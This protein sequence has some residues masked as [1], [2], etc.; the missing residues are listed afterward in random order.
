MGTELDHPVSQ[1]YRFKAPGNDEE[2]LKIAICLQLSIQDINLNLAVEPPVLPKKDKQPG[3]I[4]LKKSIAKSQRAKVN[5]SHGSWSDTLLSSS[6][7]V[8]E[9]VSRPRQRGSSIIM[10]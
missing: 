7:A 9:T 6:I 5:G 2:A 4:K 1:D 10:P 8:V 3:S